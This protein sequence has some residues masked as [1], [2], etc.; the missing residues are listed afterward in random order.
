MAWM[1]AVVLGTFL[2][3][4]KGVIVLGFSFV[5]YDNIAL[6]PL[7]HTPKFHNIAAKA[8]MGH[9]SWITVICTETTR[10]NRRFRK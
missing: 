9:D 1:T 2:K 7:C 3:M 8:N 4:C 5:L 10:K 6:I